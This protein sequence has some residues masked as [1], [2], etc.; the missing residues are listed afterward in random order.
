MKGRDLVYSLPR[1]VTR[2]P[3]FSLVAS[4]S[5]VPSTRVQ[6]AESREYFVAY[7]GEDFL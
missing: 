7:N 5:S 4:T 3:C 2:V 1:N 6:P